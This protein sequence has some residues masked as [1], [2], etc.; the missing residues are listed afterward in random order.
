MARDRGRVDRRIVIHQHAC[1]G[2]PVIRHT[3]VESV[4][5]PGGGCDA[6][7]A[8]NGGIDCHRPGICFSSGAPAIGAGRQH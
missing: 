4:C 5:V 2:E 1:A 8:A 6:C 7:D 3:G